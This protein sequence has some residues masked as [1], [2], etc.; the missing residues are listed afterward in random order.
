MDKIWVDS[1]FH[2]ALIEAI[3]IKVRSNSLRLVWYVQIFGPYLPRG[4]CSKPGRTHPG[5]SQSLRT[6]E[7]SIY[8]TSFLIISRNFYR[9]IY[10]TLHKIIR[11]VLQ[12]WKKPKQIEGTKDAIPLGR[13]TRVTTDC[14]NTTTLE[15]QQ[16]HPSTQSKSRQTTT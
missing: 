15:T 5:R 4:R 13:L 10:N 7:T 12:W 3:Y 9:T 6:L 1:T 11:E 2:S 14:Y 16:Q 8:S